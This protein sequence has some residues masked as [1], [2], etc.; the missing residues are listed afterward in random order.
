LTRYFASKNAPSV[1]SR[2]AKAREYRKHGEESGKY[3]WGYT[4]RPKKY[5]KPR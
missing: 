1:R 3:H 2:K 5:R 4:I